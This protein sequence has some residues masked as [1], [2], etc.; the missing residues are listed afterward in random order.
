MSCFDNGS[1]CTYL[2]D[3]INQLVG[4][5][6]SNSSVEASS[7]LVQLS[8]IGSSQHS[9]EGSDG[10]SWDQYCLYVLG[11]VVNSPWCWTWMFCCGT[12]APVIP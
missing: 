3:Y 2:F 11:N 5:V 8:L 6:V 10:A 7:H 4:V 9:V 1:F 12:K